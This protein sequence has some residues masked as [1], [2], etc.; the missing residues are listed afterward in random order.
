M[1]KKNKRESIKKIINFSNTSRQICKRFIVRVLGISR[2]TLKTVKKKLEKNDNSGPTV[3]TNSSQPKPQTTILAPPADA[4]PP[5]LP[6]SLHPIFGTINDYHHQPYDWIPHKYVNDI[7]FSTEKRFQFIDECFN[8][9]ENG[10]HNMLVSHP[11]INEQQAEDPNHFNENIYPLVSNQ[12]EFPL[13][14]RACLVNTNVNPSPHETY[15]LLTPQDPE[16]NRTFLS[17]SISDKTIEMLS[18]LLESDLDD[19][20]Q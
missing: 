18:K 10:N 19:Q 15:K 12:I 11:N 4:L 16:Y 3:I 2:D 20:S 7:S 17:G 8:R 5:N 6:Q 13:K 9:K 1:S 14:P